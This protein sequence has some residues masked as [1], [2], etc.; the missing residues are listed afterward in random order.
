[1][2]DGK[3]VVGILAIQGFGEKRWVVSKAFVDWMRACG[4]NVVVVRPQG[5]GALERLY[6]HLDGLVITGGH[7]HPYDGVAAYEAAKFFFGKVGFPILGVCMGMQYMLTHFAS[8]GWGWDRLRTHVGAQRERKRLVRNGAKG[9]GEVAGWRWVDGRYHMHNHDNCI[10]CGKFDRAGLGRTFDVITTSSHGGVDYV[11]TVFG[12]GRLKLFGFQWHPEKPAHEASDKQNITRHP[13]A[14]RIGKEIGEAFVRAA[15]GT[16]ADTDRRVVHSLE[17][18]RFELVY[19][20][21]RE[22]YD[23]PAWVWK[24]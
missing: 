23:G 8:E 6:K 20:N 14:K 13:I 11:S 5:R 19:E 2:L 1:M 3:P 12:K 4:A 22:D 7:N 16:G 10:E 24:L 15:A 9:V 17:P 21:N 18:E